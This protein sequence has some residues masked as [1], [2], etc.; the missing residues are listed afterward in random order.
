MK[1]KVFASL[2]EDIN[3]GWVW[4]PEHIVRERTV[5]RIT[6]KNSGKVVYCEALQ[7]GE[8]Y[9]KRYNTNDKTYPIKDKD[10]SVVMSE[11]YRKRLGIAKTQDEIELDVVPKDNPWGHI[12]ASL[13]HP[14]SVVRLA[15]ELAIL[16]AVLG[17]LGVWL[18]IGGTGT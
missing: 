18:G 10:A 13:H 15:M 2:A 4:V 11:W 3:N 1:M 7:I 6:N 9:L 14:Q 8:N 17:A 12:K 16:S 5:V